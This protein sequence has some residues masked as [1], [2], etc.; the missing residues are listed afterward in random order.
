MDFKVGD[1]VEARGAVEGRIEAM[2]SITE[3]GWLALVN[4]EWRR[5]KDLTRVEPPKPPES[6]WLLTSQEILAKYESTP[7]GAGLA[8]TTALAQLRHV[9]EELQRRNT[10][11]SVLFLGQKDWEDL[12]RAAGVEAKG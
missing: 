12:Q 2:L 6:R 9:V 8:E 7:W 11:V 3:P 1:R 4:G 5:L 10:A